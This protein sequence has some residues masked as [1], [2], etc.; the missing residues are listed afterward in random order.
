M[1]QF[2]MHVIFAAKSCATRS[3]HI[4]QRIVLGLLL[5][6]TREEISLANVLLLILGQTHSLHD[7]SSAELGQRIPLGRDGDQ[8]IIPPQVIE[9][10]HLGVLRVDKR[11]ARGSR[12]PERTTSG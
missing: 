3:L 7:P 10:G 8:R 4:R 1:H 11:L 12:L 5:Y 9:P 2:R 6:E